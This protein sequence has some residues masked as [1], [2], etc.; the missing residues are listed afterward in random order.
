MW[1]AYEELCLLGMYDDIHLISCA[2]WA[3]LM[4]Y[5]LIGDDLVFSFR[6][7]FL[8]YKVVVRILGFD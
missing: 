8:G 2:H 3:F 7:C 1:T 6:S 4:K 5:E